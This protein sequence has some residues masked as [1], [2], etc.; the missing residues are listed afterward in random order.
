MLGGKKAL[1][2]ACVEVPSMGPRWLIASEPLAF[3]HLSLPGRGTIEEQTNKSGAKAIPGT[4]RI[5]HRHAEA[6]DMVRLV[7]TSLRH[8]ARV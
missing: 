2:S 3:A 7:G 1:I 8:A 6:G 4:C 5:H